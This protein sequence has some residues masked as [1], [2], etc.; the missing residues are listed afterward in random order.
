[1]S[2]E[3]I[4]KLRKIITELEEKE[5]KRTER[6]DHENKLHN[7]FKIIFGFYVN[8]IIIVIFGIIIAK[9]P[10]NWLEALVSGIYAVLVLYIFLD[11]R[12]GEN[13]LKWT[14]VYYRFYPNETIDK[15]SRIA[16][17]ILGLGIIPAIILL[18]DYL[19]LFNEILYFVLCIGFFLMMAIGESVSSSF[20]KIYLKLTK[21]KKRK[22]RK[23][24]NEIIKHILNLIPSTIIVCSIIGPLLWFG[25]LV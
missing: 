13:L 19:I 20:K 14:W 18:S 16:W 21:N 10:S 6:E 11:S 15:T 3:E 25:V 24:L 23:E 5:K 17:L 1:M 7:V 2:K 12:L 9:N 4:Q 22:V 8:P